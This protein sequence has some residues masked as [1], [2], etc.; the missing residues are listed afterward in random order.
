MP[1]RGNEPLGEGSS[2]EL[3]LIGRGEGIG[4]M[5]TF[6]SRSGKNLGI[7]RNLPHPFLTHIAGPGSQLQ[8]RA[9]A[10]DI[11]VP[12]ICGQRRVSGGR[13]LLRLRIPLLQLLYLLE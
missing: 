8:A 7:R 5:G 12:A 6:L 9:G 10:M 4:R 11:K 3:R 2:L 1:S 13:H